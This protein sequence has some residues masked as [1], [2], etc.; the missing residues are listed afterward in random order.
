MREPR[1]RAGFA[2]EPALRARADEVLVQ[3]LERDD[4]VDRLLARAV[5]GARRAAPEH[6]LD[7]VARDARLRRFQ[8]FV[9]H[10]R[11][12]ASASLVESFTA[13]WN[14]FS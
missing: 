11:Q 8:R 5:D 14:A 1:R 2:L 9:N 6:A 4:A 12:A 10:A 7:A 3:H 13:A